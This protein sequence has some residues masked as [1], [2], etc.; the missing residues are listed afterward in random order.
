MTDEEAIAEIQRLHR[1]EPWWMPV[2]EWTCF[3]LIVG[4]FCGGVVVLVAMLA[5][6]DAAF[7]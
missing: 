1:P 4:A 5:K 2:V 6:C 3:A 7:A